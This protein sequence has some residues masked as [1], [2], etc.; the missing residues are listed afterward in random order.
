MKK[1]I[2]LILTA[3]V[4]TACG[5]TDDT[6]HSSDEVVQPVR[7]DLKVPEK[8]PTNKKVTFKVTV[9]Q[10]GKAVKNA[11]EVKFEIWKDGSKDSSEMIEAKHTK[12]G[13]YLVE[14]N[15]NQKGIY[16]VQSHVT[17]RQ[18][19][20]MPKKEI[21]VGN[22]KESKGTTK[23]KQ[24]HGHDHSETNVK[25][26]PPE[27]ITSGEKAAFTADVT[28]KQEPLKEA[29]VTMEIWQKNDKKH[30]WINM[31]EQSGATYKGKTTF[32]KKGTYQI[33]VHVKK[34]E[35]HYHQIF[36]VTVN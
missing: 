21:N 4:L 28:N 29:S 27:T 36:K 25:F 2:L 32:D 17:A 13:I 12:D 5:Q 7:A 15:F 1:M 35:I 23:E 24:E 14:K 20:T 18:M 6:S 19:H 9:K 3:A 16:H 11:D 31:T 34:E 22:A 33:K 30:E 26:Q 10:D 8:A